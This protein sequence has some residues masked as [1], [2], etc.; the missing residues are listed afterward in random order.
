VRNCHDVRVRRS[1][2][3]LF[4]DLHVLVDGS[5]TLA[6]AHRLTETIEAAIRE[7]APDA[8][9]TVHPEPF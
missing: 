9:V 2:S 6:E 1:G 5:Q 4:I 8:D 3:V 7:M